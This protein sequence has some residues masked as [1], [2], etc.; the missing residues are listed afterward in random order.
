[1]GLSQSQKNSD[2]IV[3][4][5]ILEQTLIDAFDTIGKRI[6]KGGKPPIRPTRPPGAKPESGLNP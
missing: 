3:P 6:Y 4:L 2:I 5:N 1:L